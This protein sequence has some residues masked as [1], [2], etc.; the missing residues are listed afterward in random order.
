MKTTSVN[1]YIVCWLYEVTAD[2]E[3]TNVKS[4][5]GFVFLNTDYGS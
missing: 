2:F 3:L 1:D 4:A 5:L